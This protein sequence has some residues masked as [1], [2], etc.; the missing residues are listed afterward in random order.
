MKNE[1][2]ANMLPAEMLPSEIT[3]PYMA[4]EPQWHG[5]NMNAELSGQADVNLHLTLDDKR[6]ILSADTSRNTTRNIHVNT[7]SAIEAR[8]ML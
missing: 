6:T 3:N 8:N 4:G 5:M 2:P 7:G 1:F